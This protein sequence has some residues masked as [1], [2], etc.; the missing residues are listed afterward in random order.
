MQLG[1][2]TVFCKDEPLTPPLF[3]AL[4]RLGIETVELADYHPNF[5]YLHARS[6]A[7]IRQMLA[8]AGLTPNSVHTHFCW[9]D[10]AFS[11][12]TIAPARRRRAVEVYLRGVDALHTL[13][14][15]ILVTHDLALA[16]GP[17][18]PDHRTQWAAAVESLQ[19]VAAYAGTAGV[20][21]A[22]ENAGWAQPAQLRDLVRQVGAAN[23]GLCVDTGHY[24]PDHGPAADAIQ[25]AG[26]LL[27]TTHIEDRRTGGPGH[28]LPLHGSIDWAGVMHALG[29]VG[30][31]GNFV[32]ELTARRP[33]DV[34]DLPTDAY[35]PALEAGQPPETV[36]A[37]FSRLA[38][39]FAQLQNLATT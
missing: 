5:S 34:P 17:A 30:Y 4:R 14:C 3:A 11:L 28:L 36:W 33:A 1:L 20:S 21:V 25:A 35:V 9:H 37:W 16:A 38:E 23:V 26:D 13:G 29:E 39:N 22:V 18:A 19:E 24:A 2:S 8:D 15:P 7:A 12:A 6:L 10:P 32:Y 27:L 31:T